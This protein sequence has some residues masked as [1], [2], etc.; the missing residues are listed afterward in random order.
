MRP[1]KN[2]GGLEEP[3]SRG[4]VRTRGAGPRTGVKTREQLEDAACTK[5]EAPPD[6][7]RHEVLVLRKQGSPTRGGSEQPELDDAKTMIP[8]EVRSPKSGLPRR[9]SP[10]HK[11]ACVFILGTAPDLVGPNIEGPT[12]TPRHARPVPRLGGPAVSA[13]PAPHKL[14]IPRLLGP[15]VTPGPNGGQICRPPP[16]LIS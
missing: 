8:R 3:P 16:P 4:R 7:R 12:E 13:A 10:P 15:Q 14:D 2:R 1:A 6:T 11:G 9:G 5:V